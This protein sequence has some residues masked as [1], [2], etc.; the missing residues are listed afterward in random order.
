MFV[1]R[2]TNLTLVL[3][4]CDEVFP[5]T[6]VCAG[7]EGSAVW[8]E[9][10]MSNRNSGELPDNFASKTTQGV[11]ILMMACCHLTIHACNDKEQATAIKKTVAISGSVN[12]AGLNRRLA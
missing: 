8:T 6:T 9:M 7:Y 11:E 2:K 1:A 5:G 3:E 12:S 4:I 10:N